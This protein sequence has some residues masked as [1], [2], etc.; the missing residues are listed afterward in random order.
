MNRPL[1]SL[2]AM[3]II[4]LGAYLLKFTV[5]E[6]QEILAAAEDP[7]TKHITPERLQA[8]IADFCQR[9]TGEE[10]HN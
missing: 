5:E 7:K 1:D 2:R 9:K 3:T 10:N 8:A 4:G 6:Q